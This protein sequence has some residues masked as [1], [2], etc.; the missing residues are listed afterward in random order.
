MINLISESIHPDTQK[1]W[2][3]ELG[4]DIPLS[5]EDEIKIA[6]NVKK[7]NYRGHAHAMRIKHNIDIRQRSP[8]KEQ[9]IDTAKSFLIPYLEEQADTIEQIAEAAELD[10]DDFAD[11]ILEAMVEIPP[12]DAAFRKIA[13]GKALEAGSDTVACID[14]RTGEII[15][16]KIADLGIPAAQEQRDLLAGKPKIKYSKPVSED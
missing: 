10:V 3:R 11:A 12:S 7:G 4:K 16:R 1:E 8:I 5:K 2:D 15:Y 13:L 6:R 9:A 14:P